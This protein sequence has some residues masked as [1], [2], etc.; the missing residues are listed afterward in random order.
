MTR[1]I[2]SVLA[3]LWLLVGPVLAEPQERLSVDYIQFTLPNG[4]NVILHEDHTVPVVHTNLWYLVG[5]ANEKP[6]RTGFAH[7][8]EH[9][10]FE[11]SGHVREGEFDTLLEGVGGNNNASTSQ[12]RTN[13]YISLPS[14]A[15]EL[16]LF[17]ESD[18]MGHLLKSV[19]PDI[20]DGQRDVVKNEMRQSY[21]NRPYGKVWLELPGLL[22]PESH[23]YS[24]PVIGSLEDIS[25]AGFKDVTDF[26]RTYY[27]PNNASLVVAGDIDPVR[28]RALVEKWFSDVQ[29]GAP[30]APVSAPP[31]RLEEVRRKTLTDRVEL[32]LGLLVWHT[33][34]IL[35]PGDAEMDL[36]ASVLC[37][38]K[39][40]RLYR[41]LVH[42][43]QIAQQ[44][45]ASQLSQRL[46][47]L[48][49]IQFI[50][51]PGHTLDEVQRVIDEELALLHQEPPKRQEI[52][53]AL[54][55]LEAAHLQA[56]ER[57]SSKADQLNAYYMYTGNP[58]YFEE[59]LA[60]Y[61][62]ISPEDLRSVVRRFLPADRRVELYVIPEQEA[63]R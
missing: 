55:G 6:G 27:V 52:D 4:L 59:D 61:R 38:S 46:G 23:P 56:I 49:V 29:S 1:R 54:N 9:L 22:Y 58:D 60:R 2:L 33:P 48:F 3:V 13:Y 47:S 34:A 39:N 20:V 32:P 44:V 31:V 26:F 17:L 63:T 40:S 28:T 30:V 57:A 15:L 37:G 7:L 62:A 53:R 21:L 41:R 43:L 16:A 35:T 10:M 25:A 8:F 11:G 18:R 45:S 24:W 12:D 42:E 19:S 5:S 50:P 14:N 36:V 51:R